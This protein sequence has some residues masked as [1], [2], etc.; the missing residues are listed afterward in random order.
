[1]RERRWFWIAGSIGIGLAC[2]LAVGITPL[3]AATSSPNRPE[4]ALEA[5]S[6]TRALPT[7]TATAF[8][9]YE[10]SFCEDRTTAVALIVDPGL[11]DA[12][13]ANLDRFEAD[14]CADGYRVIERSLDF[15][16]PPDLRAYLADLYARTQGALEGAIFL[17]SVPF[18]YQSVQAE[19]SNPDTKPPV[20]E[21]ISFQYYSDLDGE[22][23]ASAGYRSQGGHEY[24][25]DQ[26]TGEVDWE[27]WT[28]VF[29]LYRGDDAQTVEALNRYFDKNHRY[30]TG[31][32]AIPEA[33]RL[34]GEHYTAATAAEQTNLMNILRSGQYSW[35]PLSNAP[36]AR[37]FF[38]GPTLSVKDG[39]ADLSAGTA[40]ITVT[41]TH[42]DYTMSG[43]INIDWVESQPVRTVLFWTDGCSVGN[44]D[45]P[46][47]FLTAIVYSPTSEV[48]VAKGSTSDSGGLGTNLEGFYGHN[49]AV[50]LVAGKNLGQAIL[51]HVNV[52][53]ISPWSESREFH[54]SMLIL[55]G[56]PTL[57]F[58][59]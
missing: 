41:E 46:E 2:N 13:R 56:D 29:P 43:M 17:G 25:F 5:P 49:V 8:P 24:S 7:A 28:G 34:I 11:V 45:H 10:K 18:A 30:R 48:L 55:I 47:N 27:I 26:H 4:N 52:P 33:F 9:S 44:L 19:S 38:N 39:Y 54:F 3:P 53:L 36:T 42:G 51:G 58:R 40:D 6:A 35:T 1:M 31:Q 22:F 50:R 59:E 12:V 15:A 16:A 23:S 21:V 37:I 20:E 57:R 32:Y 14:L